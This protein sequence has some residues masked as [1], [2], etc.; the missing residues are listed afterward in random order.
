MKSWLLNYK[1]TIQ[2]NNKTKL[3]PFSLK[4]TQNS[5]YNDHICSTHCP[6][7]IFAPLRTLSHSADVPALY[8][9]YIW[10]LYKEGYPSYI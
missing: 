9:A 5:L 1:Q 7:I 6:M 4:H 2:N 8:K 10:A 3:N